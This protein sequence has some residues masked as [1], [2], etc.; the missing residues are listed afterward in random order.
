MLL[1]VRG[2]RGAI[3]AQKELR[4]AAG[5]RF[6]Q[7]EA[8]DFALEHGQTVVVRTNATGEDRIAVVQQVMRG[9]GGGGETVSRARIVRRLTRGDVLH[10][11]FEFRE[12]APQRDELGVD[13]NGLAVEQVNIAGSHL[14]MHQQQQALSLHR[15]QRSVRLAEVRH[16]RI[17][18]G[19]GTGRVEFD[20]DH[21]RVFGALDFV[22]G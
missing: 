13:E 14:A 2:V 9:N 5:G 3:G 17:A 12:I 11:D 20:G 21:T 16:A 7:S 15:F 1:E 19:G 10:H 4:R 18:V 22:S 6:N 8:M